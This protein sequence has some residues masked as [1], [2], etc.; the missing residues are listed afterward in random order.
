MLFAAFVGIW[1]TT[2]A[3]YDRANALHRDSTGILRTFFRAHPS[4]S[5]ATVLKAFRYHDAYFRQTIEGT[6]EQNLLLRLP[7]HLRPH[8]IIERHSAPCLNLWCFLALTQTMP[9]H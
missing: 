9:Q 3:S 4:M 8:V 5:K 6:T 7:D 2:I 1:T